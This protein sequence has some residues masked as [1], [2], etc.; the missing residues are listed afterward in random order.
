MGTGWLVLSAG[1]SAQEAHLGEATS[2]FATPAV[3]LLLSPTFMAWL[4]CGDVEL[5]AWR[6]TQGG[7]AHVHS[8]GCSLLFLFRLRFIPYK[9][10]FERPF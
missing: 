3:S 8:S 9:P 6:Q 4:G 2:L 7:C 5:S 1:G 10:L